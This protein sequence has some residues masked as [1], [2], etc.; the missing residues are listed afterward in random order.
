MKIDK[1]ELKNIGFVF[2]PEY[3]MPDKYFSIKI[4]QLIG[5]NNNEIMINIVDNSHFISYNDEKT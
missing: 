5:Q 1:K 4:N 2:A 3:E